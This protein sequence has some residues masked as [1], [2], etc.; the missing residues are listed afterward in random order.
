MARLTEAGLARQTEAGASRLTEA[1]PITA[2]LAASWGGLTGAMT[3]SV[4][5]GA[6]S[7]SMAATWG[8]LEG[9]MQGPGPRPRTRNSFLSSSTW[10]PVAARVPLNITERSW[11]GRQTV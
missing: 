4:T 3:A 2:V 6:I 7:A 5:S 10:P 8:G 1:D 11:L 9:A